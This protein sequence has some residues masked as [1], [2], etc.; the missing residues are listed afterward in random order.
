MNGVVVR[1]T[2]GMVRP[3]ICTDEEWQTNVINPVRWG[4][5]GLYFGAAPHQPHDI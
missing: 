2:V 5:A 3:E 1:S 4:V